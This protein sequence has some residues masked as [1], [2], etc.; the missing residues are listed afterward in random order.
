MHNLIKTIT[1]TALIFGTLCLISL[2]YPGEMV[3]TLGLFA[4]EVLCVC[5]MVGLILWSNRLSISERKAEK[6]LTKL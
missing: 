3:L 6:T 4:T 1:A 5:L 2:W